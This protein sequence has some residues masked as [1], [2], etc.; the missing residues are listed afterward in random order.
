[1]ACQSLE[2][3]IF[4]VFV[5]LQEGGMREVTDLRSLTAV[6]FGVE[7]ATLLVDCVSLARKGSVVCDN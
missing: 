2:G 4:G 7:V 1:M 6:R 3:W 5:E